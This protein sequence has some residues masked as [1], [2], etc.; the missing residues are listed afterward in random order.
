MVVE[1]SNQM[2]S[3]DNEMSNENIKIFFVDG[4]VATMATVVVVDKVLLTVDLLYGSH[5]GHGC[6]GMTLKELLELGDEHYSIR[7]SRFLLITGSPNGTLANYRFHMMNPK[8][9][10]AMSYNKP[11]NDG[12][13]CKRMAQSLRNMLKLDFET[14]ICVHSGKMS[15]EVFCKDIDANWSWL[16]GA[17]LF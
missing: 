10:G 13:T 9:L 5:D 4:D 15:R 7:L 2:K 1:D 11:A 6:A 8:S 14:A 16:D 12:S 17:S 3:L